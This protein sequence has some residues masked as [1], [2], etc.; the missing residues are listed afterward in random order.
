MPGERR[1]SGVVTRTRIAPGSKS[2]H[3][4]VV[5]RTEKGE[6]YALRRMG[7][8]AFHDEQLEKLVD[9]TIT[10]TGVIAGNT[11][12]MKDWRTRR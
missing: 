10:A 7:G 9:T 1:I 4:G 8:N 2:D 12:I 3:V 6:E 5:L 11:F